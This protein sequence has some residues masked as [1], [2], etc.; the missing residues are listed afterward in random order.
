MYC[1]NIVPQVWDRKKHPRTPFL[2]HGYWTAV[3]AVLFMCSMLYLEPR[4]GT[5]MLY[6]P[7]Y[8]SLSL[9]AR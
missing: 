9:P 3:Q 1:S 2:L 8:K 5:A 4:Y 7:W 6:M